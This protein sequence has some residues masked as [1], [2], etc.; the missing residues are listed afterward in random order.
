VTKEIATLSE[1]IRRLLDQPVSDGSE[2]YLVRL[3]QT[4]TEGYARALG[5][6]AERVR[7]ERRLGQLAS[8]LDGRYDP[9]RARELAMVVNRVT[10][11]DAEL[12]GLRGLLVALRERFETETAAMQR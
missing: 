9:R 2:V 8:E 3:E 6:E 1:E 4:L 11:A 5:L 10:T 7:L 12:T